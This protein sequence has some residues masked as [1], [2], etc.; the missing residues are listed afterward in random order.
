MNELLPKLVPLKGTAEEFDGEHTSLYEI[1]YHQNDPETHTETIRFSIAIGNVGQG[2]LHII[3]GEEETENGET[4]SPAKQRIYQDN[5][6]FRDVDVGYL[7]KHMHQG[8][9]GPPMAH[10]HYDGLASLDLLD[11]EGHIVESSKKDGYCIVDVFKFQNLPNSPAIR[12]FHP[13]ACSTKND[14]GISVGWADYYRPEADSQYIEIDK[15]KSGEYTIRFKINE[16]KLIHEIGEP[17]SIRIKIDKENKK[18]IPLLEQE[19]K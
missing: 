1:E 14:V 16:T 4:T 7:E 2:P 15:V 6:V 5:G 12:R 8:H 10:W 17:I 13:E 9:M 18:V 19:R 3:L 11:Q